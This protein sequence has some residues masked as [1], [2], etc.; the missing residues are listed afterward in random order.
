MSILENVRNSMLYTI[1]QHAEKKYDGRELGR[2]IEKL[3]NKSMNTNLSER[4]QRGPI[5]NLFLEVLDGLWQGNS[6]ELSAQLR[7]YAHKLEKK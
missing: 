2:S 5:T 4:L 3:M 7:A 1:A 6:A